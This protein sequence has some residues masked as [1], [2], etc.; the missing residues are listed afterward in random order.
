MIFFLANDRRP[1]ILARMTI[2]MPY[3]PE[4]TA[5]AIAELESAAR[6]P[7][8]SLSRDEFLR[9][10]NSIAYLHA[11]LHPD[12]YDD[13]EGGWTDDLRAFAVE[14]W[15]R[16]ESGDISQDEVY[17]SDAQWCG[18]CDRIPAPSRE[19]ST[20][21]MSFVRRPQIRVGDIVRFR[22]PFPDEAGRLMVI[23]SW[24]IDRG[25]GRHLNTGMN[26][27]PTQLLRFSEIEVVDRVHG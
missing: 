20:R 9:A 8:A 3:V 5:E 26:I 1:G 27:P 21:R 11:G 18:I 12:H 10:W 14:A 6:V 23:T 24:E 17:P 15:R 4:T 25:F 16:V 13:P 2:E 7:L 19:E 22:N